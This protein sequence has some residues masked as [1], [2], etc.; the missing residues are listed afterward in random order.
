MDVILIRKNKLLN[1][2]FMKK[3]TTLAL[4][5]ILLSSCSKQE[6]PASSNHGDY[7]GVPQ[8]KSIP[9]PMS[10]PNQQFIPESTDVKENAIIEEN[11]DFVPVDSTS[12]YFR[13][14]KR[15]K[16]LQGNSLHARPDSDKSQKATGMKP[17]IKEVL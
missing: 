5:A 14:V 8:S 9:A 1:L 3:L 2:M 4:W 17:L 7:Y 10:S 15:L 11:N 16:R 6:L 13:M 12:A